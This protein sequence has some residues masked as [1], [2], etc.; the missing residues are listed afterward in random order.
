TADAARQASNLR[1]AVDMH[2]SLNLDMKFA[3]WRQRHGKTYV[4]EQELAHRFSIFQENHQHVQQHNQAFDRGYTLYVKSVDGPFADVTDAEFTN[5]HLMQPQ[6]CSATHHSSGKLGHAEGKLLDKSLHVD[7]RTKGI[8]T[9]IKNQGH[10]GSCWTFSTSGCLEAHTCLAA[11]KDCSGWTGLSEEQLVECAGA[12]DNHGCNGG[13]PSHAYE[14]LKYNGG[15]ATEENYPYTAPENNGNTTCS[16]QSHASDEW[17]AQVAEVFNITSRDE[18]DLVHAVASI[19]PVSIAYQVSPD[20]RFYQHGIY[21]SYNVTTNQTMCKSGNHD[22]NHAVVAVGLGTAV[23]T[24][25]NVGTDYFIVR[26]S[27][28]AI[29]KRQNY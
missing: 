3:K 9:P 10:C 16:I 25:T 8:M 15:M 2:N 22:V 21:D 24:T 14:Y 12:F 1:N 20:F 18:D 13:L 6:D 4:S 23:N 26:N 28:S 5:S 7:W 17:R 19:G 27:W 11:G 29:P